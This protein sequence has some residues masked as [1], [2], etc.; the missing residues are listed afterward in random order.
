M[1]SIDSEGNV[2]SVEQAEFFKNSNVRDNKGNLLVTYHGTEA[3]FDEFDYDYISDDLKLGPGFYFS[4]TPLQF[5]YDYVKTC[6]LNIENPMYNNDDRFDDLLVRANELENAGKSKKAIIEQISK[7]F[8][9]DGIISLDRS[10]LSAVA[11][12]PNQIKVVDNLTPTKSNNVNEALLDKETLKYIED[13]QLILNEEPLTEAKADQEKLKQFLNDDTY[14]N[15]FMQLKPSIKS[16]QNDIYYWLKRTPEELKSFLD[17]LKT[18]KDKEKRK[19]EL[20]KAGSKLVYQ[21]GQWKV[22]KIDNYEASAKYGANTKWCISGSK[23]WANGENGEH[24]FN[25]YY[26]QGIRFY[27]FIRNNGEKYAL[28][29]YPDN[30][31]FEIFNSIDQ[32][33]SY[34]PDA[35]K[36][37]EL[38]Q[39]NYN[40]KNNM[41]VLVNAF[42]DNKLPFYPDCFADV[43][44]IKTDEPIIVTNN[45]KDF[46]N[47][48]ESYLVIGDIDYRDELK[49]AIDNN[50]DIDAYN[51]QDRLED[52]EIILG[53]D[54]FM[55]TPE[56]LNYLP[57]KTLEDKLNPNTY[58]DYQ[59]G[60]IIEGIYDGEIRAHVSK[61]WGAFLLDFNDYSGLSELEDEE[62]DDLLADY[63]VEG[64][65]IAN[66]LAYFY[67]E[68]LCRKLNKSIDELVS[69]FKLEENLNEDLLVE[70][71]EDIEKFVDKFGQ[72][73][74]DLFKKSTQ[75]LKNNN[76]STDI[77]WHTKHTSVE[78]MKTI[79]HNLQAKVV[80][81]KNGEKQDLTKIPG[82]Y[83][84]FGEKNGYKV[85]QPLD[86][87]ASMALGVGSGWCTTGRYGH[88]GDT[89][90]KPSES[91]AE[92]HFNSYTEN[93]GVKLYYFLDKDMMAKYAIA[94]YPGETTI[95][96]EEPQ[97]IDNNTYIIRTNFEIYNAEDELDYSAFNELPID[98]I[99]E[100]A[101]I[102]FETQEA[103]N[104]L[105]IADN[106]IV[107]SFL[108]KKAT[109]VTI[110]DYIERIGDY[111][112]EGC[113]S[114]TS[115]KIPNSVTSIGKDAFRYCDK[116]TDINIPNSVKTIGEYAFYQC[117]SL[118][119]ITI[120]DGVTSI[121]SFTFVHCKSLKNVKLPDS[122]RLIGKKA[123]YGCSALTSINIPSRVT[124]IE[125]EAFYF[126]SSLANLVIPNG[127]IA[128][129]VYAFASCTSLKKIILPDSMK[130][131]NDYAFIYCRSL[132]KIFIPKSVESIGIYVFDK[133]NSLT[134][135]C[136]LEDKPSYWHKTWNSKRPV[137]WGA[138]KEQ[139]KENLDEQFEETIMYPDNT[140]YLDIKDEI[141]PI[142][143]YL[144]HATSKENLDKI[145][146]DGQL[147]PGKKSNWGEASKSDSIYLAINKDTAEEFA[148]SMGLYDIKVLSIPVK[149]LDLNKLYVD[150]NN[151]YYYIEDEGY[152]VYSFEYKSPIKVTDR[153]LTEA[154]DRNG[155]DTLV[156]RVDSYEGNKDEFH[157]KSVFFADS[158]DYYDYSD[159]RYSKEDAKEYYLN[160]RDFKVFDPM[161]E[162]EDE[163]IVN[164]W[165]DI[166]TT[167]KFAD[168]NG[169]YYE[170][171]DDVD[172]DD[173]EGEQEVILDTD[174]LA[175]Y[176]LQNGYDITILRDIPQS[177]T[178]KVFTEY[179]VHNSNAVKKAAAKSF[180][181]TSF[182]I[183]E[184]QPSET[185]KDLKTK[186]LNWQ[187]GGTDFETIF[188]SD[189]ID[190]MKS[191]LTTINKPIYRCEIKDK[192]SIKSLK[193]G[194][195][196]NYDRL[197]SF[198]KD[199]AGFYDVMYMWDDALEEDEDVV[200]FRTEGPV[201][202]FDIDKEFELGYKNVTDDDFG[203]TL[204][205]QKEVFS[206]GTFKI[207]KKSR[208]YD[209][210][211]DV[212]H[213]LFVIRLEEPTI[214]SLN[215][216]T[217]TNTF[218]L[219]TAGYILEDGSFYE[220]DEYH[221]EESEYRNQ[222]LPEYS[223]THPEEDTCVRI[224]K[225][226][227]KKQYE[228]LEKIIDKYLD[229]E[230]YCKVELWTSPLGKHYFY[231]VFSLYEG[232]CEDT[233]YEETIGNWT[234][235][236]LVQ[237]IK[238]NINRNAWD[239]SIG[240]SIKEKLDKVFHQSDDKIAYFNK[241]SNKDGQ[242][243]LQTISIDKLIQD[244]DL[245]NPIVFT[246][247]A[248]VWG[249]NEDEGVN[250]N[251][252]VY[253]ASK[254]T[255]RK[256][257]IYGKYVG[258]KIKL[259][260]GRHRVRALKNSGYE[261]IELPILK[262]DEQIILKSN[263]SN[264]ELDKA[265]KSI[266]VEADIEELLHELEQE[267][268]KENTNKNITK[269]VAVNKFVKACKKLGINEEMQE[270]I[271]KYV[272][273][274]PD[275]G[276]VIKGLKGARKLRFALE[277]SKGKSGSSRIIYVNVYTDN[278]SYLLDIYKKSSKSDLSNDDR[279]LL[280][281]IIDKLKN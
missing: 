49:D 76:I 141:V 279:K 67:V 178:D 17:D 84:Y 270:E 220:V 172:Y 157:N 204:N 14:Y 228:Q 117:V 161:K 263:L 85:Y 106:K 229:A 246:N 77:V 216:G 13:G 78:D 1:N 39:Y 24:Y 140:R 128:I 169:L 3:N 257:I 58:K 148:H 121:E 28:V 180:D 73:V 252:L 187:S 113:T 208:V 158:L 116:L 212:Y 45:M 218:E 274:H 21:D 108:N 15:L 151:E 164:S 130:Y 152:D 170:Y 156:Y 47:I 93:Y 90:F 11:F 202:I 89:S 82:E 201:Q 149:D 71:K 54:A 188:S 50:Y 190:Y 196:I 200:C 5:T 276:D 243:E 267:N 94:V 277:P 271:K 253:D 81:T 213:P 154:I 203:D 224:Y 72:D 34:I 278:T 191:K 122:I 227:N 273:E 102:V 125:G 69:Y 155:Y 114:L 48:L 33:I 9:V 145:L 146:S 153:N 231:K 260:N 255:D 42:Y 258:N 104:G 131:I 129:G 83:K 234:G 184:S 16:P 189:D 239:K 171:L 226:P 247:H 7:E 240:E 95:E 40:V 179:A 52:Q 115:V 112:F 2:L 138:T 120:P 134:I 268:L 142:D 32:R 103:V 217:H 177:E 60:I 80:T 245:N 31:A 19:E 99:P 269:V 111:A 55:L 244:N 29:L 10:R 206:S 75:R 272:V 176:G 163:L 12:F 57:G 70:A 63:E 147:T 66:V 74:Y 87:I 225:E 266:D 41:N 256:D 96:L 100:S 61:D 162:W 223:N 280:L 86:Y 23:Q 124:S 165:Y 22:Y 91:A 236:K 174:S 168:E 88:Y 136:E 242:Y 56:S 262:E 261:F 160:L 64:Q 118:E 98:L 250:P 232:A 107:V 275:E 68:A 222:G 173:S 6:Y 132:S 186:F 36:V 44:A 235:Y 230:G 135:Y 27:F 265:L 4:L 249:G 26:K 205:T 241:T 167:E 105:V 35:P 37:K 259:S 133:C 25:D 46:C 233:T 181:K 197:R 237:I 166:R 30:K 214:E 65:Y 92:N 43:A 119:N 193:V 215:E 207:V 127:C 62:I 144:Y 264:E 97:P 109:S 143:D 159:T 198:S 199:K 248:E 51:M 53:Q 18:N 254:D 123:F 110:P 185:N 126:C 150:V 101:G 8:G 209:E 219:G 221:G 194:D 139:I 192:K 281:K 38:S 137:V 182:N 79:L 211:N 195:T 183:N 175:D 210:Y 20:A 59:Y 238:N 251:S